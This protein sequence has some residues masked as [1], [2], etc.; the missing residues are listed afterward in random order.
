MSH[1]SKIEVDEKY[2][3]KA[4]KQ[5]CFDQNW[6]F[7]ENQQTYVKYGN[8][9]KCDHA[10]K[11]PGADY[12]IGVVKKSDGDYELQVDF[13][14]HSLTQKIGAKAGLMKQAYRFAKVHVASISF[15]FAIYSSFS[16]LNLPSTS[17]TS[18]FFIIVFPAFL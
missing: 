3:I 8:R 1:V 5:M 15:C 11:I 12:E 10:I 9:G 7:A 14:D 4:L 13:Y 16:Y 6:V 2:D 18:L 17:M